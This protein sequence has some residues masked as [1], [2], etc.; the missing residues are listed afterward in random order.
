MWQSNRCQRFALGDAGWRRIASRSD[1]G[2]SSSALSH[3]L[4]AF[5]ADLASFERCQSK[6]IPTTAPERHQRLLVRPDV[7]AVADVHRAGHA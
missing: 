4:D 6:P 7:V 2:G 3:A 5:Q 1:C